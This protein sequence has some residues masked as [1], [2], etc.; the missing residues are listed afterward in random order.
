MD[1]E[2]ELEANG[3]YAPGALILKE[4]YICFIRPTGSFEERD[5]I[6]HA[7]SEDG[8][9]FTRNETNPIVRAYGRLEQWKAIDADVIIFQNKLF[10]YFTTRDQRGKIQMQGVA[11]VPLDG[12]FRRESWKQCC[13]GQHIAAGTGLGAGVY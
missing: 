10:L 5:A 3:I 2:G 4:S 12:E 6:C 13:E 9:H 7:W 1:M 11:A 8:V